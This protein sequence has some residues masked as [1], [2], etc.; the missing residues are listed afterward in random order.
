M[1]IDINTVF[2]KSSLSWIKN[3]TIYLTMHGS[4]AYGTNRP[5]SDID[6]RGICISPIEYYLGVLDR[7]EQFESKDPYDLVIFDI[8]KFIKLS[9]DFNPN[10]IELLFTDPSDHLFVAPAMQKLFDIRDKFISKKA[11]F[12]QSG[13]A[14]SQLRRIQTHRKWIQN[15]PKK[16]PERKDFGLP[17]HALIPRHQ[18]LEIEAAIQKKIQEWHVDT[19]GLPNDI[20][21]GIKNSMYEILVDLK[22]NTDEYDIY[23]AKTLGLNDNLM[24]SFKKERQ[25]KSAKREWNNYQ[26]WKNTRN[27]ERA[28]LEAK[29]GYD[30]KF[31]LHLVRL[32]K[33]CREV[34]E[35]GNLI[36]KRQDANELIAIKNGAWTFEQLIEWAETQERELNEL[37]ERSTIPREPDRNAVNKVCIEIIKNNI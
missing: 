12:T 9:L 13:Y 26:N 21:I 34:L 10:A 18:L 17:D 5:D 19:T 35:T 25:Y 14:T 24:E 2:S 4:R 30:S 3:K 11:K 37:Y 1:T 20:A 16:N 28:V 22:I 15:P 29:Y 23:A 8:R 32:Y 7:F 33:Q 27:E 36:I 6:I 31:A